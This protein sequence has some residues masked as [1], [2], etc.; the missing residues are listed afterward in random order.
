VKKKSDRSPRE[1]T[2]NMIKEEFEEEKPV[3]QNPSIPSQED[4]KQILIK[5]IEEIKNDY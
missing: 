2:L 5:I 4:L 3:P 1:A